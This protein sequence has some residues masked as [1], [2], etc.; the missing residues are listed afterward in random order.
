[1]EVECHLYGFT[2]LSC[3]NKSQNRIKKS[4]LKGNK[5]TKMAIEYYTTNVK[6]MHLISPHL[7]QLNN[8]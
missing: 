3:I 1:M 6:N 7:G 4:F 8:F 5:V 2:H